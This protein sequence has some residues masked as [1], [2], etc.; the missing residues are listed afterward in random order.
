MASQLPQKTFI[1]IPKGGSSM[2]RGD[3]TGVGQT[4]PLIDRV[5]D[6]IEGINEDD[7]GSD[8][9]KGGKDACDL[10]EKIRKM[11]SDLRDFGNKQYEELYE[12]EKDRDYYRDLAEKYESEVSELKSEVKDLEKQLS[13]A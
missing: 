1:T 11:N 12:M 7:T 9:L 5:R 2:R 6:F 13:E 4:C 10:L 3:Y 8:L